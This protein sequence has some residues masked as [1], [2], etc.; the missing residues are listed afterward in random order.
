MIVELFGPPGVGKTTFAS[1]LTALLRERGQAVDSLMS[2]R[3][4]EQARPPAG[5]ARTPHPPAAP[6]RRL[7]RPLAEMLATAGHLLGHSSDFEATAELMR[8]LPARDLMWAVRLRQYLWRLFRV[9][10]T[11]ALSPDIVVFDQA[12]VQAVCSLAL[13]ARVPEGARIGRALDA[14]PQA[15]LLIQLDAPRDVLEARLARRQQH[16]GRVER[17]LE[18]DL[19]T[20]LAFVEVIG[21]M[22]ARLHARGRPVMRL[23]CADQLTLRA[24]VEAAGAAVLARLPAKRPI[25]SAF[26]QQATRRSEHA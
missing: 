2:Y 18:L 13:L 17:L 9:W 10:D 24:G 11:A 22:Q 25:Q 12:F 6:L 8:L 21:D 19:Q 7:A 26:G 14:I 15:D 5:A 16:Q 23:E 20:N 4:A 3:P 1:A